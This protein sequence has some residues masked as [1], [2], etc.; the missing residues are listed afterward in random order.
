VLVV[1]AS[2]GSRRAVAELHSDRG[3]HTGRQQTRYG[4][5]SCCTT[6]NLLRLPA[7]VDNLRRVRTP[8][9]DAAFPQSSLLALW[10]VP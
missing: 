4:H 5:G 8:E 1:Q 2:A 7:I 10:A 3:V 9:L 6:R